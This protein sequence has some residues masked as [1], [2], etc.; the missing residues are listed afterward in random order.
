MSDGNELLYDFKRRSDE[1]TVKE[2]GPSLT[3][4][5]D[6]EDADINVI[7]RRFNLTGQMPQ[8]FRLPEYSDFEGITD[9]TEAALAI[10]A[11]G[12]EFMR[13]P[14]EIRARFDHDPGVFFDFAVNPDNYDALAE[15]GLAKPRE[16]P[17]DVPTDAP[18]IPPAV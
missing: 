8:N 9:F 5:S 18:A 11:G 4:Q 1:A 10:K 6:A 16:I 14:H 13:L 3:V 17:Q 15:L 2:Y 7:V 12:D